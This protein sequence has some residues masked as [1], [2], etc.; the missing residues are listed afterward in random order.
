MPKATCGEKNPWKSSSRN[1]RACRL[2]GRRWRQHEGDGRLHSAADDG[3]LRSV[4][5]LPDVANTRA[6][7]GFAAQKTRSAAVANPR[8]TGGFAASPGRRLSVRGRGLGGV[9]GCRQT[10]ERR[11]GY[12]AKKA[13]GG[14]RQ[15]ADDGWASPCALRRRYEASN[16]YISRLTRLCALP[17]RDLGR[18]RREGFV[19]DGRPGTSLSECGRLEFRPRQQSF[20]S[21]R[22][23]AEKNRGVTSCA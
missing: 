8:M 6:T 20:A 22:I 13:A 5:G 18:S 7:V 16:C 3:G 4:G 19:A 2:V 15:S 12:V 23:R 17:G 10:R 11:S 1:L 9:G 14:C 21:A